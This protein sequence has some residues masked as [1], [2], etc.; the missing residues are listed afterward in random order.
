LLCFRRNKKPLEI[1]EWNNVNE[2]GVKVASD[3]NSISVTGDLDMD[4]DLN[5]EIAAD[6]KFNEENSVPK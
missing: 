1:N 3:P 2:T 6:E 5:K 4:I